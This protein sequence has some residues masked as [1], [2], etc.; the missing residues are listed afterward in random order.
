MMVITTGKIILIFL[1][2]TAHVVTCSS[3]Y[4]NETDRVALLEF[5]QAVRLDPKQTLMSWND[6]IHFCNWEGILCSLRIPYRVTSLNLTNRGLVGQISPSL[7]NLT[8]LS[9][10]SLTENSFSGQIPAS[11]G[12]LN[13]LQ[14]LWLSNNTLQGVIPDFT[15]CSSMKA[16]RLN[17]NNLV[18][19]FPQ[20]PHCLQS[21]QLSYNHLS[22][23]IPASLANITRLNVLT[24]TYNNIQGDIPH[25]IGKLSSLQFLYVGANKLV[26]RFPQAI[27]NL[28]TLIGLSLGFNN[29]TGEAPSNLG[30]CLPNLQLLELEDN[31]FQGQIPSSLINASKLYRLELASNNF[32]GVVPRSIGKLTKLS[33]LNLQSNKLQA[34]NKQDWE[35]LDSLANCT[36]L[37]AFSIASNHLEGHVPTSLGNLSVQLVQLFLSGNQLSGGFPS[38]IANLPNL[39]YIGLDNN[40]FTGAVPK[41]LGTLSNLQQILLHE[42]MFTGFIPTSLSNLSVLGSLWLDYNKIGGPLP[43]SLGNLQTLETLSISNNKLHGSVPMEIFRIPT[44]RLID[45]SFNN[46]DG[47]LSARVGNAKQLMYLYLSSNN[48]SGDIPSSLGNCESL[49]GIKLGSNILSGSI[50]TSLG[51]IRSLKVLNLSHNN[52]SGSIHANLGKLWLLEQV[53]LSFN[54][55]S[56]EIPTE[57][58]FLNATA[59]HI[60][61]NEGLCGGA[62]NLHLPTCYVMPLNSSRSERSILLYLV[63]LFASLVSVIFIYLLLLWRGKQKKKCT[64]LT[65]FDSKFPKVS[66]N[67]LAKATEGFSASNIIGRGIYSHVYK[68]ELF[69]GR[70]VVAVKVFSLETEGA[71]HS[72]ITECNALRKVRHRNLVP[73]LT[74]CSS[75]DTKGNDFRALV[76]KLIPQGDLYSLLHSTRDSENGFTSNIITFSQRLSIVVDIADALEYLHHNNQETVVHCD[77]KPSNI[78]LDNDMKAY[79]GDF[80]LARLKA[81]AAVPSVGDSN[82][83]SMIAIKGTIGYV[84]PEYASGGQVSTAADVYSFGIVLLEVFLRKG[85]TDDMFKDGLD[86]A[87]FVSMNFPDKILDIV[88]PVLLQDELDCSKESPVAMKEIFSECLHSV[89]NIGLCCTKQSP[90]ERMDMREVAAKLHG[91]RRH[92][93]EATR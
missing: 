17:G 50:P 61:G 66:Y 62:L 45:L 27:L 52:L 85:P 67:D 86:I 87:K 15:N 56:G 28:S 36:E 40:Q 69:Q 77:I 53:D 12:H 5:K 47:Q 43:A 20:L 84:A 49:E 90:Y 48:L 70:D 82:S 39:I 2:C 64:S 22:G 18:G 31:C 38:G 29:L 7:G 25:E 24:C 41:W 83:T 16:L 14:T 44:I 57:G 88:D 3:L 21:L 46:F 89:L 8:F 37:K 60:N 78:L 91:T 75:L 34:R 42:N 93:S 10:L 92:I 9:I 6:S 26:G 51:N 11:L 30:N 73:I 79:V 23:T 63:I 72:F 19:K 81:D 74:V 1:A 58:I 35:F 13:H 68:G 4:G 55:L 76:Y 54:N 80:G 71:E 59:V 32:T 65:P 33:W